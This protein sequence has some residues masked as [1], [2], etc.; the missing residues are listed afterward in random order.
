MMH[1]SEIL[2]EITSPVWCCEK[3]AVSSTMSECFAMGD[4]G[5]FVMAITVAAA[6][7]PASPRPEPSCFGPNGR[8]R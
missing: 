4:T 2:F 6:S 7:R 5:K 8:R 1:S 3:A